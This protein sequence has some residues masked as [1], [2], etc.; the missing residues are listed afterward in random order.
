MRDARR[1][2]SRWATVLS[3]LL[4]IPACGSSQTGTRAPN[5]NA[6]GGA[7]SSTDSDPKADGAGGANDAKVDGKSMATGGNTSPG[8]SGATNDG[9][10]D[11]PYQL[12]LFEVTRPPFAYTHKTA[13]KVATS[14]APVLTLISEKKNKLTNE[15]DW[16]DKNGLSLAGRKPTNGPV[17]PK[18]PVDGL[19]TSGKDKLHAVLDH[20][21]HSILMYGTDFT[22]MKTLL[23]LDKDKIARGQFDFSMWVKP[24]EV[25]AGEEM[26]TQ[27]E[28]LWAQKVDDVLYVSTAHHSFAKSSKGKNAFVSAIDANSGELRWQSDALVCNSAN[29]VIHGAYILCGYGFTKEEDFIYVISRADG[30]IVSKTQIKQGPSYL[31][32]K[33]KQLFVRAY[34]TDYVFDVK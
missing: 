23:L 33:G 25:V 6:S 15:A 22:S 26:F 30:K 19:E 10:G 31:A 5:E 17:Y 24:P 34:D 8:K 14:P 20:G 18:G 3:V 12:T 32:M 7:T 29:F 1:F 28:V 27:M 4:T 2:L 16:F 13:V 21:D 11:K 9:S